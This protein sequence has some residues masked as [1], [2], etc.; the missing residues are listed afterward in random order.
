MIWLFGDVRL[1]NLS[2]R[3]L[4][5]RR[6]LEDE[7]QRKQEAEGRKRWT[8]SFCCT[9]KIF[10]VFFCHGSVISSFLFFSN[11][12]FLCDVAEGIIWLGLGLWVRVREESSG[13][14]LRGREAST[15]SVRLRVPVRLQVWI[16]LRSTSSEG[17]TGTQKR[18][19]F[20]LV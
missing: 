13:Q 19:E 16:R 7:V 20:S 1:N 2:N 15:S 14:R 11:P 8:I 6:N 10:W 3:I 18:L 4:H 17:T 9:S 5:Q 12:L